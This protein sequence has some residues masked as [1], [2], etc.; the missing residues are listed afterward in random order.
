MP[1]V[2]EKRGQW[3]FVLTS[4]QVDAGEIGWWA[5]LEAAEAEVVLE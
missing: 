3:A 4:S 2:L 5:G 1:K